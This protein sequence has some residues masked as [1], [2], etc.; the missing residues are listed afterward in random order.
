MG[1]LDVLNFNYMICVLCGGYHVDYQCMQAQHVDY[2]DEFQFCTSY[3]DHHYPNW[4]NMHD[5]DW[6]DHYASSDFQNLM[7]SNLLI[8]NMILNHLE[9]W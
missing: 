5:Y 4:H 1:M 8:S 7:I 6:Y 3:V 9:N 2:F